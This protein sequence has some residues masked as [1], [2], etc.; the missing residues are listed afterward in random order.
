MTL[1]GFLLSSVLLFN[2]CLSIEGAAASS[3]DSIVSIQQESLQEIISYAREYRRDTTLPSQE[4]ELR[5]KN[6]L[7]QIFTRLKKYNSYSSL[8]NGVRGFLA[9][10]LSLNEY[11]YSIV[12]ANLTAVGGKSQDTVF[13]VKDS[14]RHVCYVVKA[15]RSPKDLTSMFIQEISALDLIEQLSLPGVVPIKPIAFASY[16]NQDEE[17]GLLLET[18][19]KGE[20]I[21]QFIYQLGS[22]EPGSKERMTFLKTCQGVFQRM[23]ES[24]AKLHDRKS[25]QSY[26]IPEIA[27]TR[28]Q[29]SIPTIL[30]SSF[31]IGE[32]EKHFSSDDFLQYVEKIKAEA[33]TVP[34]FYSYWHG[35]AH[36]GNMFYDQINNAFYFIDVAN[37]HHA[38]SMKEEP[39]LDGTA[40][41][42]EIDESLRA[43]AIGQLSENEVEALLKSFYETYEKCS[44]QKIDQ[45]ILLFH[46]TYKKLS[47]LET[48]SKYI[49]EKDPKKR[50]S[51][52]AIFDDA[53]EYFANQIAIKK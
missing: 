53:V 17:W 25:L 32:L 36:L 41:L 33:V 29:K 26:S 43:R 8:E 46:R 31:I 1:F 42:V 40:D 14:A 52:K 48:Y 27:L 38:V 23:A 34:L 7:E 28:Y 21:D 37:L 47:R 4:E 45:Q 3:R 18:A 5:Q 19:A 50:S 30:E 15:F 10:E 39:L 35:D 44:G 20:R 11:D 22:L 2:F 13:L 16:S 9:D 6:I 12:D 49:D 24:F 51:D